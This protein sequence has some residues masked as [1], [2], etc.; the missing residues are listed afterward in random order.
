MSRFSK[1]NAATD[2]LEQEKKKKKGKG[3]GGR[4]REKMEGNEGWWWV[5]I[6][7]AMEET[8]MMDGYGLWLMEQVGGSTWFKCGCLIWP[9]TV[10]A[11]MAHAC[12]P[13]HY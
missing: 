7:A 4:Q 8:M 1:S 9:R 13:L 6:A 12:M 3:G 11:C 10:R 2:C 5:I